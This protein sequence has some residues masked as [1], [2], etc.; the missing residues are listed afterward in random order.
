[1]ISRNSSRR[2]AAGKTLAAILMVL[3]TSVAAGAQALSVLPVN[4]FLSSGQKAT[5]LTIAN[6]GTS[7]TAIQIRGYAWSQKDNDDQ[8]TASGDLILS[9]PLATIAPGATQ[10]VRLIL[11]Q[12]P[13]GH[14]ATYRILIDQ[15]PPPAE[16]GV[17]HMVLRLSIPIFALPAGHTFPDVQFHL[18]RVGEKIYLVGLNAGNLHEKI[19][20]IVLT[21]SDGHKL[22]AE[23]GASPY[24]L[25]GATRRWQIAA[26]D[27]LP[28]TSEALQLTAQADAGAID[29]QVRLVPAR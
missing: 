14:E 21:T 27:S 13:Q 22:K 5:S 9:P 7:N 26:Q 1:M 6:Q 19:R 17:V 4:I 11:R 28:L 24:L 3:L 20:D 29:Q 2:V 12:S 25:S 15:I 10:V 16:P 23:S 18:E 8:L